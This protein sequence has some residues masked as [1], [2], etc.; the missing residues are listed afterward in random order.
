VPAAAPSTAA[1]PPSAPATVGGA[2]AASVPVGSPAQDTG[3]IRTLLVE[4][5]ART[6]RVSP[7]Q[8]SPRAAFADLG[9]DS[10]SGTSFAAEVSEA[11]G[12]PLN[13]TTLYEHVTLD[14]L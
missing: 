14:R 7:A 1:A 9:V 5:L 4:R 8:V 12:V 13:P 2:V 10:I 6:L 3:S 11:L